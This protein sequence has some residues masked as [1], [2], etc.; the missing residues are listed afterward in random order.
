MAHAFEQIQLP[1]QKHLNGGFQ[2]PAIL[3]PNPSFYPR[4]AS[5]SLH[6]FT[7]RITESKPWLESLLLS[8]GSILFRGFPV[9][10]SSD[11]NAVVEAFGF[12]E[13]PYVGGA[14]PR[15]NV[16]GRV[17][18]ANESPPDSPI[19]FHHEMAQVPEYPTK[20]FFFCEEEPRKGGETPI[21]LSH[22]IYEKMKD[23]FPE[24]VERLEEH[25]LI[26][27]RV[28]G[29]GDDPSSPIGRGWQ[30][31]FLTQDKIEAEKRASRLGMTL[32]W[33][34]DGV[35]TI[36]GPIP[37]IKYDATRGRKIWFNS[38]AAAYTGW[39]DS[40]NDPVKAVTFGD[41]APLPADIILECLKILEEE[42]VVIP[43]QKGDVI[44]V[45]NLAVLHS[46]RPFEPPRRILVSICK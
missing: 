40:R 37:A 18:T 31:T 17:F 44:L 39:K 32:E 28:L 35:K 24:F 12:E 23:R 20:L 3:S 41:G 43:W 7:Q 33:T 30:S 45:D 26:Y 5:V 34:E 10:T 8:S 9:K 42:S 21:V 11:F 4:S 14:A 13:L 38:M 15:T 36:I 22:L 19:P 1:Q 16:F 6:E 2:F 46:R 27:T 25:G 29:K